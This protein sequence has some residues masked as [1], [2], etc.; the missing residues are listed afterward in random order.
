MELVLG[1]VAKND[2]VVLFVRQHSPDRSS[3]LILADLL[4][5]F[6]RVEGA[7]NPIEATRIQFVL[8]SE[9]Q[10]A[11]ASL[12][13]CII[14]SDQLIFPIEIDRVDLIS[15]GEDIFLMRVQSAGP[16]RI[17]MFAKTISAQSV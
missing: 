7:Y 1:G 2:L 12:M 3:P 15:T 9:Y 10:I 14:L 5:E 8:F 4:L 11:N 16:D 13:G 17:L 6:S